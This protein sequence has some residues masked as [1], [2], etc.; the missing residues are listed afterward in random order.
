MI[1]NA[2]MVR[3]F[4]QMIRSGVTGRK[5][6][7]TAPRRMVRDWLARRTDEALFMS[8]VGQSPSL[9]D[10]IKMVHPKPAEPSRD[11]LYGYLIGRNNRTDLLPELVRDY[12]AFKA[13][14]TH[15]VPKVPFAMLTALA[16]AHPAGG[17]SRATRRGRPRG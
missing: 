14:A 4:V 12:E 16:L 1:D 8:S 11:A 10:V 5:S 7:G 13:G 15:R 2:K 6:L 9:G 3:N 17:R